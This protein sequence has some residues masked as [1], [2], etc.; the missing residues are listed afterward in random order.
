MAT[1]CRNSDAVDDTSHLLVT[2]GLRTQ[3]AFQLNEVLKLLI[4]PLQVPFTMQ[5][6]TRIVAWQ[7]W[8]EAEPLCQDALQHYL[9]NPRLRIAIMLCSVLEQEFLHFGQVLCAA[10]S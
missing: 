6:T 7:C 3:P 4:S 2:E 9:V 5:N 8:D 10:P 1:E